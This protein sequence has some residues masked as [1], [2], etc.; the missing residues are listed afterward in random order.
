MLKT[1]KQPKK[2]SSSAQ[3]T[4]AK[5]WAEIE[6]KQKR[7]KNLQKKIATLY[8]SFQSE[9]LPEEHKMCEMLAQE[10][11]HLITFLP[12]KSFTKWQYE[13]LSAWIE[14]NI[15]TLTGHPFCPDGLDNAVREEYNQ[16]LLAKVQVLPENHEFHPDEIADI[17]DLIEELM[18]NSE[19][20]SDQ[21]LNE[22]LRDPTY[23][24]NYVQEYLEKRQNEDSEAFDEDELD[25]EFFENRDE[26]DF[27]D[28][29]FFQ[30]QE[31][32][33]T[34]QQ[35]KL[36]DL[37]NASQLKKCYKILAGRLHPDKEQDPV[38]KAQKSV[39]MAQLAQAKKDKD[40]FTIISLFQQYVPDNDLNLDDDLNAELI[41]LLSEK[42]AQ[43]NR[44]HQEMQHTNT[45]ESMVWQKLG[46][47]TKKEMLE[48]KQIHLNA[49]LESQAALQNTIAST[50]TMKPLN[51]F[52]SDRY[53]QRHANPFMNFEML[54]ELLKDEFD[55]SSDSDNPF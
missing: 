35:K 6:K 23:F 14:S 29:D 53:E 13:E 20:F 15:D 55:L 48:R 4:F 25:H 11:R 24:H 49:L 37:F 26:E 7:N 18:G 1:V 54:N 47:R 34:K 42:S 16:A 32:S 31:H 28:Q 10:T 46:G 30:Q 50:K 5:K 38:L 3:T 17:R 22:F 19:Q 45:I 51:K 36:K 44:E 2:Q 8:T 43:L 27:Y 41:M 9:I 39:L 21:Q 52:L 40:A 12:R 33:Q